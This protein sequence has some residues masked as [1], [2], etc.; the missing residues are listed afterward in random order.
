MGSALIFAAAMLAM[1]LISQFGRR[2]FGVHSVVLPL[3]II[4]FVCFQYLHGIPTNA[5]SLAFVAAGA[6]IGIGI[7]FAL[8]ATIRVER[9][10]SGKG[11]TRAGLGY[12]AIWVALLAARLGFVYEIRH[13]RSFAHG[14]GTFSMNLHV[15][16]SAWVPFFILMAIAPVLVRSI[17]VAV[18]LRNRRPEYSLAA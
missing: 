12:L 4:A 17:G 14:V 5:A 8:L 11:Y 10:G 13:S 3:G 15:A 6:L 1:V 9:D 16:P 18:R 7:G 2:R